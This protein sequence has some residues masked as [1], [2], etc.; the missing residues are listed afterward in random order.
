M[1][2]A[3]AV[4]HVAFEDLGLLGPLLAAR[5]LAPDYREAGIDDLATL[6]PG[7]GDLLIVL[8]GPIGA[9]ED[10]RYPF[11]RDALG[12][13]E[14]CLARSVPV[15]GI[16]LGAQLLARVLGARVTRG[17]AKEIGFGPI[18]L[19][20]E[21]TAS[22]LRHLGPD[23]RVLHWHGDVFELPAGARRLAATEL[24]PNQAFSLGERVLALQFHIEADP[25]AFERWLI[26]HAVELSAGGYDIG[27]LRAEAREHGPAV[28][29]AGRRVLADWLTAATR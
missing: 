25:G 14:R 29:R 22:P 21:G 3:I 11:L 4:R 23:P 19:T 24:T 16:C 18:R 7:D 8:G 17:A 13:I 28:A 12:L 2:R 1:S 5:G 10:A 6:V 26:G 9:D 20:P 15:L 27:R